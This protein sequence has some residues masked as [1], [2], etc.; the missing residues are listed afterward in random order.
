MV[1][2]LFAHGAGAGSASP[3][4]RK[5]AQLLAEIGSVETFDYPYVSAGRRRPDAQA[6][7]L[8]AH[9]DALETGRRAHGPAVVLAGKSMGGRMG[10][11]LALTEEVRGIVCFGYPL[12]SPSGKGP[13]RD[14]VLLEVQR[15]VCFLQGTKD[16]LCPLGKL[17]AVIGQRSCRSVLHV[18]PSGDHS[19]IAQKT[20]LRTANVTQESLDRDCLGVVASFCAG[21]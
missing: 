6:A 12:V 4:M 20:H 18:V 5:W 21:L 3:W 13:L 8:R 7:L 1:W 11:H 17:E 10:C 19:L 15:P 16:P 14:Q 9:A 2:F